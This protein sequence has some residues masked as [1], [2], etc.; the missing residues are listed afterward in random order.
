M[1]IWKWLKLGFD[2]TFSGAWWKQLLW[3]ASVIVFFFFGMYIMRPEVTVS[4]DGEAERL[5]FWGLV[6]LF[7]D[8][9]GFANQQEVCRPYALL[10][11]LAGMLLLT[12]I[13]ISV[14]SNMLERRVERFRQGD[15]HYAFSDHVM[16]LG[17][18]DMVPALIQQLRRNERYRKCDI[19]VLTVADTEQVRRTFH[20]ELERKEERKLVILHGRRDS[21]E[22]LKKARV[23]QARELFILGETNEYDRDSLNIDCVKR[24][25]EICECRKRRA[26]LTC[27]VLFEY[28]GTFSVFQVSDLSQ[29]IKRYI[30]FVPFN[31]YEI[32]AR[33]VLVKGWGDP[34]REIDYLPLDREPL[35]EESEKYVHLVIVGMTR[36]GIALAIEAAHIAHYPNFKSRGRKT[37]ITFIDQRAKQEM[38]FFTGRYRHLFE[39]SRVRFRDCEREEHSSLQ[40]PPTDLLDLE[41]EFI[42]GRAESKEV[43][44]LLEAW[45]REKEQLLT[46]AIC[47][48]FPHTSLALGLYLPDA[49]Y[50]NEIPV[51]I[52]Q[53]TS[54]TIL[55]IVNASRKYQALRPFGM[56]C[57]GYDLTLE[58]FRL[59]QWVNY[60]Y[61]YYYEHS[62]NPTEVPSEEI[63]VEKWN[64][65]PVV[66]QWS[67]IYNAC[68]IPTKLRSVGI[69]LLRGD[70]VREL[71]PRE[72]ELLAEVEHNRW[73]VE[74]LLLG[75][76][77]VT[78]E[79]EKEIENDI[80]LKN[81]YKKRNFAHYDIRPYEDLRSDESGRCVK[82]YDISITAAIPFMLK[83]LKPLAD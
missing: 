32:W 66:K 82:A 57:R 59:P 31:F 39:V 62:E 4:P 75:Y 60:V 23:H 73:N 71:T 78:P 40:T 5:G 74:E 56:L 1:R 28:Q 15:S 52:R 49:V 13:L 69:D 8:P 70:P 61:D 12:G 6:E 83:N 16:I 34:V 14:F 27:H 21:R 10:V 44:A 48:N 46:I 41:W 77:V 26:R 17:M 35:T 53:E 11:V 20:A 64:R 51:W 50:E 67:N 7:I 54:D 25:A 3:L 22:D 68:S 19:V 72:V 18:D 36:M 33:R 42:Q 79:E 65:L 47:F 29:Q 76:R 24:V 80:R 30:E 58:D 45:S 38:D 63:L 43:Q 55:Q 81:L 2:Q 9:G 37:R